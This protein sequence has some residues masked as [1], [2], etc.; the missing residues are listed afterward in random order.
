MSPGAGLPT[1]TFSPAA[2]LAFRLP[3]AAAAQGTRHATCFFAPTSACLLDLAQARIDP[4]WDERTRNSGLSSLATVQAASGDFA[5]ALVFAH[6]TPG[7]PGQASVRDFVL[8]AHARDRARSGDPATAVI[9]ANRVRSVGVRALAMGEI[10]RATARSGDVDAA[11]LALGQALQAVDLIESPAARID[12]MRQISVLLADADDLSGARAVLADAGLLAL[13]LDD[14][15]QAL[16][17]QIDLTVAGAMAGILPDPSS[18]FRLLLGSAT[19][20]IEDEAQLGRIVERIA[21]AHARTGNSAAGLA[22]AMTDLDAPGRERVVA[23]VA[24]EL[25]HRGEFATATELLAGLSRQGDRDQVHQAV[26]LAQV[27][28]GSF[29]AAIQSAERIDDVDLRARTLARIATY[30]A[31]AGNITGARRSV[32]Q[33]LILLLPADVIG[34]PVV[35]FSRSQDVHTL[36]AIAEAQASIDALSAAYRGPGSGWGAAPAAIDQTAEA[37]LLDLAATIMALPSGFRPLDPAEAAEAV[38]VL[39]GLLDSR[40][41]PMR[42]IHAVFRSRLPIYGGAD[43]IK[44]VSIGDDG[45][46][47]YFSIL[48]VDGVV[49]LLDGQSAP[50]HEQNARSRITLPDE[51]AARAYLRLF[52]NSLATA[53]GNGFRLVETVS[54]LR[55]L[56]SADPAVIVE[57]NGMIAPLTLT[58]DG[59]G[60]T[61]DATMS[62]DGNM[63]AVSIRIHASGMNEMTSDRPVR[64]QLP[65]SRNIV[66]GGF[67][68][69][70]PGSG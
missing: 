8:S 38:Q 19:D 32:A 59:N 28:A 22:L 14:V 40:S 34:R 49:H 35:P 20:E 60:W 1:H 64:T 68:T 29:P 21:V 10:A 2:G 46:T 12:A 23:A 9:I 56:H 25:G 30:Q 70:R 54:D 44:L 43:W 24:V 55:W 50:I 51:A 13:G 69:I 52:L 65:V 4:S 62:F 26:A 41:I 31:R 3:P 18:R 5:S 27:E 37:R 48:R 45:L 15:V 58:P 36:A 16:N 67:W 47:G 6:A 42:P 63:F 66:G 61:A 53:E 17:H 57:A 39:Q 7:I 11:A 33:A